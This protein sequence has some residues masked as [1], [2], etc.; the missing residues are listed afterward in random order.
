MLAVSWC[1]SL[2]SDWMTCQS[3]TMQDN[4]EMTFPNRLLAVAFLC[5]MISAVG[6]VSSSERIAHSTNQ[7]RALATSSHDRFATIGSESVKP[8]PDLPRI[9]TEA[10]QGMKEQK[11]ILSLTDRIY[12]ALTGVEDETPAWFRLVVWIC[13]A[14]SIVGVAF[15][16]WHLGLGRFISR[17]LALVT[18]AERGKAQMACSLLSSDEH[19]IKEHIMAM[20]RDDP[21]FD[22]AFR[23]VA[24]LGKRGKQEKKK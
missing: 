22:R 15:L 20:R 12:I 11:A 4:R 2:H 19:H 17:W 3:L 10:E 24:P 16:V 6:C 14:L 18:P 1:S 23:Q 5:G 21:A 7:V 13:I 9:T 8:S